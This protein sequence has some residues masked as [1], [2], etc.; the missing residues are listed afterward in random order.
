M[1]IILDEAEA[2]SF[3]TLIVAQVL[4]QVELSTE[5]ETAIKEWRSN[6][7]E[8]SEPLLAFAADMNGVLG[9]TIDD[10]LRRTIRRRDYYRR[11]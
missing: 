1:Q 3:M 6:L 7:P 10:A 8:G 4:D 11:A 2:W 5:A 9:N